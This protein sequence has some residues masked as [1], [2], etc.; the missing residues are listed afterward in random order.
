MGRIRVFIEEH[1]VVS[2]HVCVFS[3]LLCHVVSGELS[4]ALVK[5]EPASSVAHNSLVESPCYLYML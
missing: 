5:Y 4:F 3:F 2:I 1:C